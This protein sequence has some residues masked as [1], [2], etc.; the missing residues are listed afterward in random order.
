LVDRK[1]IGL[2]DSI[3]VQFAGQFDVSVCSQIGLTN[4]TFGNIAP[5]SASSR[6]EVAEKFDAHRM[7]YADASFDHVIGHAGLHHCSRPH[8]ALHEMYRMAR[9]VVLFVENQDSV[10]MRIAAWRGV[11]P[12]Y[13]LAAVQ[14]VGRTSG[15]VDGTGIANYVY[16]WTRR[17]VAK[18]VQS[19]DPGQS[20]PL[21]FA[22]E[23]NMAD[24][25]SGGQALR[26]KLHLRSDQA[27]HAVFEKLESALN[28][29]AR[30]QGNIFAATIRK[31]LATP[32]LWV[33]VGD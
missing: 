12:Y 7:P 11:V 4:C 33:S 28:V 16:R 30:S 18:A 22:S 2:D 9:K 5:E 29:L 3:F 6:L 19:F 23:W 10:M 26:R 32:Q 14:G 24:G 27:S 20:V 15:G 17:E 13:E 1:I 31:D 8:E 25:R 21:E